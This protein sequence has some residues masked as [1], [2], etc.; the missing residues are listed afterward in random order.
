M[1]F[2]EM[3]KVENLINYIRGRT[4]YACLYHFTGEKN[5]RSI[6]EHGLLS[7]CERLSNKEIHVD[8]NQR[9]GDEVSD[10]IDE[11]KCLNNFVNLSFIPRPPLYFVAQDAGRIPNPAFLAIDPNV[12]IVEG[13]HFAY[14]VANSRRTTIKPI[15]DSVEQ[16]YKDIYGLDENYIETRNYFPKKARRSEILVPKKVEQQFFQKKHLSPK[17]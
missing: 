12:L 1:R 13:V 10:A 16:I 8:P 9:G 15:A 5:K 2:G 14:G 6:E 17:Q 11:R 4:K 7:T 3:L